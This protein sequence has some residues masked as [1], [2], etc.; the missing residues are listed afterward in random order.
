MLFLSCCFFL[1]NTL[2]SYF[3]GIYTILPGGVALLATTNKNTQS[4]THNQG[5]QI[6][7]FCGNA[8]TRTHTHTLSVRLGT[9]SHMFH[10][11]FLLSTHINI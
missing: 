8:H 11:V 7:V 5:F 2:F 4:G 10:N 9:S 6:V 1:R 3:K